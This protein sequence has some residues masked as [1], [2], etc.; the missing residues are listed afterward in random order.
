L[1]DVWECPVCKVYQINTD[2]RCK[3]CKQT[4]DYLAEFLKIN[5]ADFFKKI[6]IKLFER[7]A[8]NQKP[9]W[10]CPVCK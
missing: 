10:S 4:P 6:S 3:E 2:V 7:N 5:E 9:T 8:W 1:V